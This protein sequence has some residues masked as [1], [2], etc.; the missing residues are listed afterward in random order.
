MF[1]IISIIG[2]IYDEDEDEDE[3]ESLFIKIINYLMK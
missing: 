1:Y 3:D 2:S